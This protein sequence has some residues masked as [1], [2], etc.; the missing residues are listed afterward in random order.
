MKMLSNNTNT[1]LYPPFIL[2]SYFLLHLIPLTFL[3]AILAWFPKSVFR[4]QPND[5]LNEIFP[6]IPSSRPPSKNQIQGIIFPS[7]SH[8]MIPF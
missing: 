1:H 6:L 4:L 2:I 3:E 7:R 8:N 5:L